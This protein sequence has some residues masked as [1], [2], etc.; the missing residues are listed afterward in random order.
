MGATGSSPKAK[1]DKLLPL[2]IA[3]GVVGAIIIG[4]GGVFLFKKF[5]TPQ[6]NAPPARAHVV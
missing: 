1:K 3:V 2:Y 5:K 4:V 6:E